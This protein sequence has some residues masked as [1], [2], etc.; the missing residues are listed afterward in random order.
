MTDGL[1]IAYELYE[2]RCQASLKPIYRN[3]HAPT[4]TPAAI[5]EETIQVLEKAF[6]EDGK[7]KRENVARLR[8]KCLEAWEVGG[9]AWRATKAFLEDVF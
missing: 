8:K 7:R 5:R 6:G 3:G 4:G 9:T 2:V 1:D